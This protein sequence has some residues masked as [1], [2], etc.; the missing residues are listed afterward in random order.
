MAR[1]QSGIGLICQMWDKFEEDFPN[2][3]ANARLIAAAPD[4]LAA[5][6]RA[7]AGK[8]NE[9]HEHGVP[10]GSQCGCVTCEA[11]KAIA[12]ATQP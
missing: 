11:F 12:K 4:L 7:M 3:E 10:P 9:G 2:A 6:R 1:E 8:S 5:L